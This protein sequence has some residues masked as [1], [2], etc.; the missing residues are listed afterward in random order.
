[1]QDYR[2]AGDVRRVVVNRPQ[3]SQFRMG[4]VAMQRFRI[5]VLAFFLVQAVVSI[6]HGTEPPFLTEAGLT[7]LETIPDSEGEKVRGLA[8]IAK[9]SGVSAVAANFH[10]DESHTRVNLDLVSHSSGSSGRGGA[11]GASVSSQ[12]YNVVGFRE[13]T[14]FFPGC[15]CTNNQ[16]K[17]SDFALGGASQGITNHKVAAFSVPNPSFLP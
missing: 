11:T 6:G 10:D 7:A 1:M 9:A 5:A 16:A 12:N 2:R 14:V 13:F 4:V 8:S 17:V 3:A 15:R